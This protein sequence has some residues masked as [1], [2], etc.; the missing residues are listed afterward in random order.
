MPTI[1][2]SYQL[3]TTKTQ[4]APALLSAKLLAIQLEQGELD[5]L[6]YTVLSDVILNAV[7]LIARV[8]TLQ[9]TPASDALFPD[10]ASRTYSV[11][12]LYKARLEH[13]LPGI[14]VNPIPVITP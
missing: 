1:A 3:D 11:L 14:I 8:V 5:L 12:H 7:G 13:K 2:M 10:D 9:T 4:L 6:G